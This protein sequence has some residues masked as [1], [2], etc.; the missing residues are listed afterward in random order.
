MSDLASKMYLFGLGALLS[1]N[2]YQA[3]IYSAIFTYFT[4]AVILT[5]IIIN[6]MSSVA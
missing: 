5:L 6:L 1:L 3:S 2:Y 4:M